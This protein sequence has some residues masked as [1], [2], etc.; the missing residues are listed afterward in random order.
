[1]GLNSKLTGIIFLPVGAVTASGQYSSYSPDRAFDGST[2]TY[3]RPN[4]IPAWVQIELSEPILLTGFRW[5]TQ[6][7]SYRPK[8]FSLLGSNDGIDWDILY[9][10]ESPSATYWKEFTC[11]PLLTSGNEPAFAI[12]GMVRNP[13]EVGELQPKTFQVQK[14][15]DTE[16]NPTQSFSHST[17]I[18]ALTMLKEISQSHIIKV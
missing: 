16:K 5:N 1:M 6:S 8:G 12:I 15:K 3:W 10:G 18:T 2:S 11:T 17:H 4:T 7:S 9:S 14:L 13:L